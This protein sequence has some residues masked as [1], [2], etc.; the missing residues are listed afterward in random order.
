MAAIAAE[1]LPA[2]VDA[3]LDL[4]CG[5]GRLARLL[6]EARPQAMVTGLDIS[7]A[8]IA[9]ARAAHSLANL[10][11]ECADYLQFGGG[12]FDAIVTDGVLHLIPGSTAALFGKL[13][14]DLRAG[15]RLICCMPYSGT[16]NHAFAVARKALRAVRTR[17]LDRA[18][19]GIGRLLHG[20]EMSTE[21]LEERVHYMYLPPTRMMSDALEKNV[22]ASLGLRVVARYAM[23]STSAAQ[24]RHSVTV[25]EKVPLA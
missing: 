8:N 12:P 7:A 17:A 2:R 6:A 4:G 9:A 18:I 20:G 19:L 15:G 24:L 10:H 25:F 14:A 3:A 23:P 21:Q 11:F 1:V 5:T 16:Y 13:A 22:A